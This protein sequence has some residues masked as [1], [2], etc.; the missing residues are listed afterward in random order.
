M[1]KSGSSYAAAKE[2]QQDGAKNQGAFMVA[3]RTNHVHSATKLI[4]QPATAGSSRRRTM[5]LGPKGLVELS[6]SDVFSKIWQMNE[7]VLSND[8]L[9][10][11]LR[12]V[13]H[14]DKAI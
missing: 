11:P 3:R 2:H 4:V 10:R 1:Y 12:L 6:L 7:H 14:Y 13:M 8:A 5:S 9:F